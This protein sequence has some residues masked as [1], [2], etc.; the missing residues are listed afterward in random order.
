[1]AVGFMWASSLC[2]CHHS[3]ILRDYCMHLVCP[4]VGTFRGELSLGGE[5]SSL[6]FLR[7]S[8]VHNRSVFVGTMI[9]MPLL[10]FRSR[11]Q[12]YGKVTDYL[13]VVE[14]FPV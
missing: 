4:T 3:Q 9:Y 13:D 8:V 1:M 12:K 2:Q 7:C 5:L 14:H 10:N 6:H 11:V